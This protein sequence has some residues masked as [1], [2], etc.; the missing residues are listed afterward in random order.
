MAGRAD[1]YR[2]LAIP[3]LKGLRDIIGGAIVTVY[4]D[5]KCHLKSLDRR[6]LIIRRRG[7]RGRRGEVAERSI[8][9]AT[10]QRISL[11]R[12][13]R[14]RRTVLAGDALGNGTRLVS[15][16]IPFDLTS[17]TRC[18]RRQFY[19]YSSRRRAAVINVSFVNRE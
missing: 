6:P 11:R 16:R 5:P 15:S 13:V 1:L 10:S 18:A 2:S 7:R 4:N 14:A 8:A 17:E 12:Y 3:V 19:P 9:P